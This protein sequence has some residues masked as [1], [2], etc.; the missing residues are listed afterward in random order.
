MG[1]PILS[2]FERVGVG[3]YPLMLDTDL[4]GGFQVVGSN[5]DRDAIPSALRKFG[6][7]V[8]VSASSSLYR[9]QADLVTWVPAVFSPGSVVTTGTYTCPVGV[10]VRDVVYLSAADNCDLADADDSLKQPVIGI[11]NNKID[12]TTCDVQYN[13]EIGGFVGLTAG[14]TYF[15][16]TT[17]GQI[18]VTPP[19][20]PPGAIVQRV[21][22]AKNT[23]T[24]VILV[25][26]D[27]VIL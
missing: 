7:H 8:F 6:M 27:I 13:G 19:S 22:F 14:V 5:V 4:G 18:T 25:D 24:L 12:P 9:L 21:G 16:S 20:G 23:T 3:N 15:L 26:R 17:P 1:I 2:T 10:A 11:V